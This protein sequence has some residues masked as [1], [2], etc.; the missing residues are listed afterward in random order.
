MAA[1]L[2]GKNPDELKGLLEGVDENKTSDVYANA[3]A[4]NFADL[5]ERIVTDK[6][7]QG[8]KTK[9][10][11]IEAVLKPLFDKYEISDFETAEQGITLLAEKMEQDGSK[12]IDLSTLTSE[13]I[14]ELPIV[15]KLQGQITNLTKAKEDAETQF[16][17]FKD[18]Q[19]K[20]A[21]FNAALNST[22]SLFEKENAITGNA[23]KADAAKLFLST[24]SREKLSLDADGNPILLGD[25]GQ[26]RTDEFGKPIAFSDHIRS[27]YAFGFNAADPGHTGSGATPGKGGGAGSSSIVIRSRKEGEALIKQYAENSDTKGKAEARRALSEYLRDN[28]E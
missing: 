27:T 17:K 12:T 6:Y 16:S 8:I 1:K 24:I 28:P 19:V 23:S 26:A 15:A 11:A 13:Q 3:V 22:I 25:D 18:D 14:K 20:T 7:N 9:A 2:I 10:K 5:R 21:A 4:Q